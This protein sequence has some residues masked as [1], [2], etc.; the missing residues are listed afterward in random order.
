M[1]L[2]LNFIYH[3]KFVDKIVVGVDSKKNLVEILNL[4][5]SNRIDMSKLYILNTNTK[6]I[7][8]PR[9]WQKKY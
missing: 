8:D 3:L 7:K 6:G 9:S 1:S 5:V 2:C 4:N